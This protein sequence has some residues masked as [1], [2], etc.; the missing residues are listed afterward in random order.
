PLIGVLTA[1][2]VLPHICVGGVWLVI[3]IVGIPRVLL[4]PFL[5]VAFVRLCLLGFTAVLARI[6]PVISRHIARNGAAQPVLLGLGLVSIGGLGVAARL[7]A[8]AA[9]R[10]DLLGFLSGLLGFT[11][12]CA[13][14]WASCAGLGALLLNRFQPLDREPAWAVAPGSWPA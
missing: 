9:G 6:G 13:M 4:L 8:L 14:V 2:P 3:Q 7:I 12:F 1:L 10:S 5:L 11:Y